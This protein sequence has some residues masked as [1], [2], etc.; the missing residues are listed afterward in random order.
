ML[1]SEIIAFSKDKFDSHKSYDSDMKAFV[2][3]KR[4][5]YVFKKADSWHFDYFFEAHLLFD[6]EEVYNDAYKQVFE[7][8]MASIKEKNSDLKAK[9][10]LSFTLPTEGTYQV[11]VKSPY[12]YGSMISLNTYYTKSV[13]IIKPKWYQFWKP[14]VEIHYIV[15]ASK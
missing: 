5:T 8:I 11:I 7:S 10:K 1:E 12:K 14:V 4:G 15:D 6:V 3:P 2:I 9:S 13:E